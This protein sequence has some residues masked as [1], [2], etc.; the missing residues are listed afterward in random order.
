MLPIS[1]ISVF[2]FNRTILQKI[3]RNMLLEGEQ[4]HVR[5]SWQPSAIAF[6]RG[7][8]LTLHLVKCLSFFQIRSYE[9]RWAKNK[10]MFSPCY[11]T[12]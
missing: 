2:L 6:M 7:D 12:G 8:V 4:R 5:E 11:S 3:H 9:H 1:G 10:G